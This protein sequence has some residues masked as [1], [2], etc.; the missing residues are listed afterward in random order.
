MIATKVVLSYFIVHVLNNQGTNQANQS[1][2]GYNKSSNSCF[3]ANQKTC[4]AYTRP[5][6]VMEPGMRS[7]PA[8]LA[9]LTHA[10]KN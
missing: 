10:Q 4:I 3:K 9:K 7:S 2:H 8:D 6:M 5:N 1:T